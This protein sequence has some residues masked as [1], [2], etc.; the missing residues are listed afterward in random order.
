MVDVNG[1]PG[2]IVHD[3]DGST[4]TV[5]SLDIAEGRVQTV[6]AVVNPDKLRHLT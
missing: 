2:V 1:Q 4:I 5:V 3:G 6:R